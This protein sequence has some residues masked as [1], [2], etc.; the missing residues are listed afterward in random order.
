MI[1]TMMIWFPGATV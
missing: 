1:I